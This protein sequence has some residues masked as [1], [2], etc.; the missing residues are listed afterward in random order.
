MDHRVF[1]GPTARTS[2]FVPEWRRLYAAVPRDKDRSA[3]LRV[4]DVVR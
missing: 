1:L 3:E 4:F 2:M